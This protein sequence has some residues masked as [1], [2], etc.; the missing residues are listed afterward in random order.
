MPIRPRPKAVLSSEVYSGRDFPTFFV[1][2]S[3]NHCS[4]SAPTLHQQKYWKF[5]DIQHT[6][7]S[8]RVTC[9]ARDLQPLAHL[10]NAWLGLSVAS[11]RSTQV[12]GKS[13]A[14]GSWQ[15]MEIPC[16][17]CTQTRGQQPWKV[18]MGTYGN[19]NNE[20]TTINSPRK[21]DFATC[22]ALIL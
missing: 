1:P 10:R 6:S 16:G 8:I 7:L 22:T 15:V 14:G 19:Y 3:A 20:T 17:P 13:R 11:K 2:A 9:G 12:W 5:G 4:S 18:I 21:T